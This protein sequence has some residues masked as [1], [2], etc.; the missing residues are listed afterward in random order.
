MRACREAL[1]AAEGVWIVGGAIRDAALGREVR[2]V[3]LAVAGDERQAAREIGRV[4]RRAGV[5]ALR[6]VRQLA[7]PGGGWRLA[8]GRHQA[9]RRWNRGGPRPAR[10]HGQRDRGPAGRP[11]GPAPGP[12]RRAGRPR[13]AGAA[14]RLGSAA[15]PTTRCGSCG[16][17][18][19][20][21]ASRSRSIHGP[22]RSPARRRGGRRSRRASA[23]SRSC[24]C[25]SP[26]PSRSRG[27]QILDELAATP[28]LLPELEALRGV[29]QNPYHHLDVHGHTMEVLA[30]LIEVEADLEAF[31]G[32]DGRRR[33]RAARR[34]A[35]RRAHPGRRAALRGPLPRSRQAGDA[36]RGR[37]RP[38]A[39]HRPRSRRC[40]ASSASSARAC[41]RAAGSPTTWPT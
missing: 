17:P 31:V 23:S 13:G 9:A 26:A 15:S 21:P 35:R 33:S 3:D 19:S 29:E 8:R 40:A 11:G 12:A 34:A 10:L 27:L 4:R 20:P 25:C 7:R 39:V 37:G 38:G 24:A 41:G 32:A 36:R 2:D 6:G 30:R 16:R 18:G 5:Q 28:A 1:G 14:R 22:S